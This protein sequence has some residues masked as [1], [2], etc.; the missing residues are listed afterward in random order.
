MGQE[1]NGRDT[2]G[3]RGRGGG[4]VREHFAVDLDGHHAVEEE[5]HG[6]A[7]VA[8]ADEGPPLPDGADGGL[9]ARAHD[10]V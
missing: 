10:R 8:L 3:E 9:G 6:V 1:A 5:E 2:P 7:R 4:E